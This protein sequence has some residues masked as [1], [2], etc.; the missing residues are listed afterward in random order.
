MDFEDIWK[1]LALGLIISIFGFIFVLTFPSNDTKSTLQATV[2][3]IVNECSDL[4]QDITCIEK[5]INTIVE[6]IASLEEIENSNLNSMTVEVAILNSE[7]GIESFISN[8][9]ESE[10]TTVQNS[11]INTCKNFNEGCFVTSFL[12]NNGK[13]YEI[14]VI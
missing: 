12:S 7:N 8:Q 1:F 10:S 2:F 5:E 4:N 3:Q 14:I 9:D 13:M 11:K 6:R